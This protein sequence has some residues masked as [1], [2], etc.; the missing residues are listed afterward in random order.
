MAKSPKQKLFIEA[1]PLLGDNPSGIAKLLFSMIDSLARQTGFTDR[2][3]I[4]LIL[5]FGKRSKLAKWNL[6]PDIKIKVI[7]LPLRLIN[8]MDRFRVLPGIDLYLGKGVY[9]F[10]NYR[11]L[12]LA[13]SRSLT[14]IHDVAYSIHPDTVLAINRTFLE[15]II[16]RAVGKSDRIV[17][18]SEQSKLELMEIFP[19]QAHKIYVVP[20]GIDQELYGHDASE[21]NSEAVLQKVGVTPGNYIIF[22]GNIEPRKNIDYLIDVYVGLVDSKKVPSDLTLLLIG[23]GGWN[24]EALFKRI[25]VLNASG[26][27]IIRP[28]VRIPDADLPALYHHSYVTAL[29]SVHEG[30]GMTPLEALAAGA[31]VVVSDIPVLREVGA[32][33][34]AYVP[35]ND[36]ATAVQVVE[37]AANA[38]VDATVVQ[39]RLDLYSW[40]SAAKILAV[41]IEDLD[42][43]RYNKE[44]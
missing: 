6:H 12:P 42:K 37:A 9:L 26:Y 15:R 18:L 39:A 16:P 5:P 21:S 34:V 33:A 27:S 38:Q 31:K 10:P 2:Y 3:D 36:A 32:D 35:L 1:V 13:S 43:E 40:G 8:L 24:N 22:V 30:F 41:L 25:E 11:R 20:C 4:N 19:A 14:Y 17:T 23:G 44:R 7:P 29:L 28:A